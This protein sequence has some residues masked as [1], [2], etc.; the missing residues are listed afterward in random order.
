MNIIATLVNLKGQHITLE[1][2]ELPDGK[3]TPPYHLTRHGRVFLINPMHWTIGTDQTPI[4][5]HYNE[6]PASENI[7]VSNFPIQKSQQ[8]AA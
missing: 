5:A 1:S 2:F 4:M 6:Q 8:V 7:D 3:A